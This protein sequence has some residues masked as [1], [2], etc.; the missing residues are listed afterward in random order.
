MM[1]LSHQL[2]ASLTPLS[3]LSTNSNSNSSGSGSAGPNGDIDTAAIASIVQQLNASL[4]ESNVT[5]SA[6]I[7]AFRTSS[8]GLGSKYHWLIFVF[9]YGVVYLI[10]G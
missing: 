7:E 6:S 8:P 5:I 1:G 2:L 4:Q 10:S 9:F 3:H